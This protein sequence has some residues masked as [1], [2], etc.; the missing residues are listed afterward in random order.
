MSESDSDKDPRELLEQAGEQRR[1]S[2]DSTASGRED[3]PEK[4]LERAVADAYHDLDDGDRHENLT[5]RDENIAAL[6]AGLEDTDR[7]VDVGEAANAHLGRDAD[8]GS[9]ADVLKA[10]LR[11]GIDEIDADVLDAG[12]EG[13]SLYVQET[14]MESGF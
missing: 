4:S 6:V 9:R 8:V 3:E 7:L 1:H 10:L 14:E 12:R 5:V 13:R 11:V 2:D